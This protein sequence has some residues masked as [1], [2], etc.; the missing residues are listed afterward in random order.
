MGLHRSTVFFYKKYY[1]L[2]TTF[3]NDCRD[4]YTRDTHRRLGVAGSIVAQLDYVSKLRLSLST[5]L[6][7]YIT[8]LVQSVVLAWLYNGQSRQ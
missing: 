5:T 4:S 2:Q 3:K 1:C 8:S 6:R 7:I